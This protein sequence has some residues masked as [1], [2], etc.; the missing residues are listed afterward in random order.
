MALLFEGDFYLEQAHPAP[1]SL[2]VGLSALV[3]GS[4]LAFGC[5]TPIVGTIVALGAFGVALSML[6]ACMPTVFDSKPS[7]IFGLT[8][9]LSLIGLGPGRFSVDARLFGRREIILPPPRTDAPAFD[10]EK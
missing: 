2:L 7:L 6:P 5:L 9:L 1:A 10:T 8:M 4:L 3:S